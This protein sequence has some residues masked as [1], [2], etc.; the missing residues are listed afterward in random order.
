[1]YAHTWK[2]REGAER[3]ERVSE[4]KKLKHN[5]RVNNESYQQLF[6]ACICGANIGVSS[7]SESP[8][9][10]EMKRVSLLLVER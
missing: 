3:S 5:G 6:H 8:N 9:S 2:T 7:M 4:V 10:A 1:M